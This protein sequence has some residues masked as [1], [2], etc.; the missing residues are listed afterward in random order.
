MLE[1]DGHKLVSLPEAAAL[2]PGRPHLSSLHRWMRR[3]VRG[4]RLET[5]LIGGRRFTS[6]EALQRFV[7]AVSV[8]GNGASP[9]RSVVSMEP[10]CAKRAEAE[11]ARDGI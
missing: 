11:L 4:I 8:A 9:A 2:L 5:V 7:D 3:G 10:I 6:R 1:L